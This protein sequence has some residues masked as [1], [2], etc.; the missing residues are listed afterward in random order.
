MPERPTL[1]TGD[2]G[3]LVTVRARF[4]EWATLSPQ[5]QKEI[6]QVLWGD[7]KDIMPESNGT[8]AFKPGAVSRDLGGK[9]AREWVREKASFVRTCVSGVAEV[10]G[11]GERRFSACP[12][13]NPGYEGHGAYV[14]WKVSLARVLM[15]SD[16]QFTATIKRPA[17]CEI[18]YWANTRDGGQTGHLSTRG[19]ASGENE[20]V[21]LLERRGE[22]VINLNFVL[23]CDGRLMGG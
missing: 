21:A 3:D 16:P 17:G 8:Y 20:V 5:L 14:Q 19:N 10:P 2:E 1:P 13:E 22:R 12:D 18:I 6:Q 4:W 7:G 23:R 11:L 9:M 15:L